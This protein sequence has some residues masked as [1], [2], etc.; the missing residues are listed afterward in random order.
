M[1]TYTGFILIIASDKY[2]TLSPKLGLM[3]RGKGYVSKGTIQLRKRKEHPIMFQV[4][5][6]AS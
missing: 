5:G 1:P 3:W 2:T 4:E 6:A